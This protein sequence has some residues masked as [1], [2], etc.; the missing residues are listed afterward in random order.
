MTPADPSPI[1]STL[2]V[3]LTR[4]AERLAAAGVPEPRLD[5]RVLAAHVLGLSGPAALGVRLGDPIP[6]DAAVRLDALV[7]RRAAREPVGR[8]LGTRGF[9]TLDLA[10]GPD[11]LEPRP[12]T[13]TVVSAVLDRLPDRA[14]PL[15]LL[16]LGTGTGAILLALL[17]EVPRATGIGVDIAPGA[18]ET[19]SANAAA[20]GLETRALFVVADWSDGFLAWPGSFDVIVSNPPYIA[21]ADLVGLEPEVRDH[22]PA[23]ALDGGADGL[24]AY[25][26][27]IPLAAARL[28]PGGRLALEVGAGQ[29]E[30]VAALM[31][32][33]GLGPAETVPDLGGVARCVT[34]VADAKNRADG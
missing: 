2:A 26:R 22:D 32:A 21:T 9:W 24:A 19:A 8:I 15:T 30:A 11:T 14:A 18:V 25:R 34:A 13:E 12:D 23:V 1:G 6:A 5:A 4:A 17:S 3:A 33:A 28:A 10:V 27:L 31:G 29:A 16:D 7:A 20:H